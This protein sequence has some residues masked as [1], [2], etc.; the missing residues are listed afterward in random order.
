MGKML[1]DPDQSAW[2]QSAS[3]TFPVFEGGGTHVNISGVALTK[4]APNK[5][6]AI[7]LI[8][9]LSSPKAQEIYATDNFEY[10]V[11]PG[12]QAA[13]IV[14]SWGSF[15]TDPVNLTAI[16]KLRGDA[17]RLIEISDFDG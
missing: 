10:P 4:A 13:P 7:Q 15:E 9:F 1:A 2:A 3:I 16:A 6:L 5:E 12:S 11:S 17:L 14:Q 8:E